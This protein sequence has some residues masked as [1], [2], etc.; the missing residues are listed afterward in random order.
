MIKL[1]SIDKKKYIYIL[2]IIVNVITKTRYIFTKFKNVIY[3]KN[4]II[5]KKVT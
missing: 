4:K 1:F 2:I 5:L 3:C